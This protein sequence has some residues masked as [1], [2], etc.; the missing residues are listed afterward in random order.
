[1]AIRALELAELT[2][3]ADRAAYAGDLDLARRLYLALLERAPRHREI[4]ERLAWID[5]VGGDRAEAALATLVE[6]ASATDAGALGGELLVAVGDHDGAAMAFSRAA[7]AEAFG[8]L[9]ALA[10]VRAATLSAELGQRLAALDEAVARSPA[11]A[12]ARWAR[13]HARLDVADVRGAR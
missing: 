4:A 13:F 9:A 6:A 10:W 11:L 1:E 12:I 3:D 2:A 7:E 5:L 8:P